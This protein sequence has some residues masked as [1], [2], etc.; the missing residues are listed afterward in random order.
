MYCSYLMGVNDV[1]ELREN[2]FVIEEIDGDYGVKFS[3]D[4]KDFYEEFVFDNLEKGYWNEYLGDHLVF[5]F[6]FEDGRTKR[7]VYDEQNEEEILNLCR[8]F[9]EQDFISFWDMLKDNEFYAENYF[10]S[11]EECDRL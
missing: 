8:K 7:Y 5:M 9:A 6:K 3:S 4:K 1:T 10:A 11:N 2:G